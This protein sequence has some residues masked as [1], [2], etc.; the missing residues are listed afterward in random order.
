MPVVAARADDGSYVIVYAPEGKPL[1]INM[2]KVAGTTVEAKWYNP[3]EGTWQHIGQYP[4]TG[5]REFVA[6]S[7]GEQNDWVL[8]LD[9]A[10]KGS[11]P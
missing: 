8:V 9:D 10:A 5:R 1:S 11:Q 4:N 3:R 7:R 2:D 6:P